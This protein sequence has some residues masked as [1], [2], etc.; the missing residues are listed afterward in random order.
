M[1]H[2]KAT[3]VAVQ[4]GDNIVFEYSFL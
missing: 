1:F 2:R 4:K 3:I